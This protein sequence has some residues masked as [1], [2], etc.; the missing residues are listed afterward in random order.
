MAKLRTDGRSESSHTSDIWV[1]LHQHG[2]GMP[3]LLLICGARMNV[4]KK[5]W[6]RQPGAAAA[7]GGK[8]CFALELLPGAAFRR[9]SAPDFSR[10]R[11]QPA[12]S[13]NISIKF[14]APKNPVAWENLLLGFPQKKSV[15]SW[16][17]CRTSYHISDRQETVGEL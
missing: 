11:R 7:L 17:G 2:H 15:L 10:G 12:L 8:G 14:T 1:S 4:Q 13:L 9:R 5:R 3:L 16:A 6:Q